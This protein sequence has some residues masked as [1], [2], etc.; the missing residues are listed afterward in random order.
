M[1]ITV[2]LHDLL[3][4]E[5]YKE[6]LG[7]RENEVPAYCLAEY[8]FAWAKY[9]GS[10][11]SLL[12]VKTNFGTAIMPLLS[13]D[14][15]DGYRELYS[16]YGYG[17]FLGFPENG[18]N[19]EL[20][21]AV[22]ENFSDIRDHL[23]DKGI[24][25]MFVRSSP[26]LRNEHFIPEEHLQ[27]DRH[28]V[29]VNLD[30]WKGKDFPETFTSKQRWS[31]RYAI[32]NGLKTVVYNGLS[33]NERVLSAF[34][35]LYKEAMERNNAS[36]YYML[37]EELMKGQM[38]IGEKLELIVAILQDQIVGASLFLEDR[39][40][41]HYHFSAIDYRK[42]KYR[43]TDF[44]LYNAIKKYTQEGKKELHL[45][46]GRS[47]DLDEPL[48]K[49]KRGYGNQ[50]N[51]YFISKVLVD[52]TS[53]ERIRREKGIEVSRFFTIHDNLSFRKGARNAK[54]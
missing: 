29:S 2:K 37:S 46:G 28:T 48:Y 40:R 15:G 19:Q 14:L 33:V 45:G 25:D 50:V 38:E 31:V 20:E 21:E 10:N 7:S 1:E 26:F 11:V 39:D 49:F 18:T 42:A 22:R 3:D 54:S 44:I 36:D 52:S 32:R 13:F 17:G 24:I 41:V 27:F 4:R 8:L 23:L 6:L 34:Y 53:Y 47:K 35:T 9:D 5:R 51:S 12:E 43:I 30:D 16:A